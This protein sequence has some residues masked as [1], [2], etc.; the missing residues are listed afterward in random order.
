MTEQRSTGWCESTG[1]GPMFGVMGWQSSWLGAACKAAGEGS[2]PLTS[3]A[4]PKTSTSKE[5]QAG[6]P[7][8]ATDCP[9]SFPASLPR[10]SPCLIFF[11]HYSSHVI[12][13]I[14]FEG[15]CPDTAP[16]CL[17]ILIFP[18]CVKHHCFFCPPFHLHVLQ[19][20]KTK[21]KKSFR[22]SRKFPFYKS[23]ENLAQESSG[24]ERK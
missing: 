23:K 10:F 6:Y 9:I 17:F 19:S 24:R 3:R 21:R 7:C 5:E 18:T 13:M 15:D 2:C 14:S 8:R 4:V 20:I 16:H 11:L 12:S 1:E 22:L